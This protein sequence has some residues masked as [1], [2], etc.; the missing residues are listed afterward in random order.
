MFFKGADD[1]E[2]T[3]PIGGDFEQMVHAGIVSLLLF[4]QMQMGEYCGCI[5]RRQLL[6]LERGVV[7]AWIVDVQKGI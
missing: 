4:A 1:V 7:I 6:G 2:W 5:R 3:G